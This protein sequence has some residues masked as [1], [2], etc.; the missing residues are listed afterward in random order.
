M[1][2][3]NGDKSLNYYKITLLDY[4]ILIEIYNEL[5]K[6]KTSYF[7]NKSIYN[8]LNKIK[9]FKIIKCG[10]GWTIKQI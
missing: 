1:S 5:I 7:I 8:L 2:I 9:D 3:K 4:Y 6:N 10:V